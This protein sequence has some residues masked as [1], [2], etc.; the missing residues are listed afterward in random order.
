MCADIEIVKLGQEKVNSGRNCQLDVS[1]CS[2]LHG[3][4]DVLSHHLVRALPDLCVPVLLVAD[5]GS[6]SAG[7][8]GGHGAAYTHQCRHCS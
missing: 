6:L 1:G 2:A 5:A 4:D 3:P 8:C 7:G